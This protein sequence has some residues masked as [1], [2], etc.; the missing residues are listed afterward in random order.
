MSN[1]N[2]IQVNIHNVDFEEYD[3]EISFS[4]VNILNIMSGIFGDIMDDSVLHSYDDDRTMRIVLEESLH[5]YN[6]QEKKP[7]IKLDIESHKATVDHEDDSCAIC[8]SKFE[9]GENI[10]ILLCNHILHTDCISEWVKYKSECPLCR[11]GITTVDTT[12]S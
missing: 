1:N 5:H 6:T 2:G 10:T 8:T 11:G 12:D 7:N 9:S 3:V 4:Q